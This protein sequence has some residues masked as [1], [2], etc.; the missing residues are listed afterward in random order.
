M[1]ILALRLVIV[2]E[3][4]VFCPRE[5]THCTNIYV[6][7]LN[8][9]MPIDKCHKAAYWAVI[10]VTGSQ[11]AEALCLMKNFIFNH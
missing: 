5:E 11:F 2:R 9:K 4:R 7:K 6:T 8:K 10:D 3:L 1:P